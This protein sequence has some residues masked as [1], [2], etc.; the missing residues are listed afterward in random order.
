MICNF[1]IKWLTFVVI[2]EY[3]R[4][5]IWRYFDNILIRFKTLARSSNI[6]NKFDS[7]SWSLTLLLPRHLLFQRK[8]HLMHQ[9]M[10]GTLKWFLCMIHHVWA[11]LLCMLLRLLG[12]LGSKILVLV[13]IWLAW[14]SYIWTFSTVKAKFHLVLVV[15]GN[16]ESSVLGTVQVWFLQLRH[17]E[18]GAVWRIKPWRP[19]C[20]PLIAFVPYSPEKRIH[21]ESRFFRLKMF[22]YDFMQVNSLFSCQLDNA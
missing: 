19:F 16:M 3:T 10:G 2:E 22:Y 5:L 8:W 17:Y 12:I 11:I 14:W 4:V 9:L 7:R 15:F 18:R 20:S 13:Q 1:S 6:S 21:K